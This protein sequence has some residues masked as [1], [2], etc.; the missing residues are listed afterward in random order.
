MTVIVAVAIICG[1]YFLIESFLCFGNWFLLS[2]A[3]IILFIIL[4]FVHKS[5]V[6]VEY[7]ESQ[8]IINMLAGQKVINLND[9]CESGIF[10]PDRTELR[11]WGS[12]GFCGF[13]GYFRNT[14]I[15]KYESFVGDYN[16]AFYLKTKDNKY[17]VLSCEGR[18]ALLM[19]IKTRNKNGV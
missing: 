14:K 3:L 12:G 11:L 13:T 4:Y 1:E 17:F 15:G 10:K 6:S 8:L 19:K 18:D 5:P 2:V 7:N 16:Q 9:I